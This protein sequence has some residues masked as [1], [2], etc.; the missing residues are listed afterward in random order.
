MDFESIKHLGVNPD[1][2]IIDKYEERFNQD[3]I[4]HT[5]IL[6]MIKE[7]NLKCPLCKSNTHFK[8]LNILIHLSTIT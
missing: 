6:H 2:F 7:D 3:N 4:N 5:I 8:F 1:F